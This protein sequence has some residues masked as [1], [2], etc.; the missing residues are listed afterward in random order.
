METGDA[1]QH[2]AY[3]LS[4]LQ[5]KEQL[6]GVLPQ[7]Q[8]WQQRVRTQFLD[9]NAA[10]AF[11]VEHGFAR[12][13][14]V[15]DYR[16]AVPLRT[17]ADFAP[18]VQ[19]V[20]AGEPAVLTAQD[21]KLFFH[22]SGSTGPSKTI[23]VTERFLSTTYLPFFRAAMG[24]PAEYF[25]ETVLRG[26]STL[27]LR[28]DRLTA[29]ATTAS[30]RPSLGPCQADLRRS[31]GVTVREPGWDAPWAELPVPVGDQDHMDKLYLRVRMAVEHDVRTVIGHNP[32]M[33]AVLPELLAQWWPLI[34]KEVHD[35]TYMGRPGGTPNPV[36]AREL[37]TMADYFGRP[38]PAM[39]W[40]RMQLLYCWTSGV[41]SLYLPRL[42]ELYGS[43]VTILPTPVVA[44]EGPVGV[45]IDRHPTAGPLS[46][47]TCLYEFVE[48]EQDLRADSP[49]LL[50]DELT[51]GRDYH[52]VFSHVGGLY[53]YVLGDL[54]HVVDHV[55]GVPRVEYAGRSNLM[56]GA[57]ERVREYHLVR[58]LQGAAT[59][60]GL[61]IV[62]VIS[63]L[64]PEPGSLH[65]DFAVA[66]PTEPE[67]GD[68]LS[69]QG[70]LDQELRAIAPGYS[71]ARSKGDIEATHVQ[72][73]PPSRFVEYWHH[74]V[75]AGRRP[76]EVKD[77]LIQPDPA[78][79]EGIAG[80]WNA[81]AA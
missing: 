18:W 17:Y 34:L 1:E 12:I 37:E 76:V 36:R 78:V 41:A 47:S 68:L 22:T 10:T 66:F 74:R 67:D 64:S 20:A 57:G 61:D 42:K 39:I 43:G 49:T 52:V 46:V 72:S 56:N 27:N 59:R 25:P 4:L 31:F 80:V 6:T 48:A 26:S 69:F 30:G 8:E 51:D 60:T 3:R 33:I 62:N 9:E 73:I 65:Y 5:A 58:A 75:D 7:A 38:T 54:V 29:P 81:C 44:S 14:S 40:P 11:G 24:V 23:P 16:A 28:H 63:R 53:R 21:P 79:F 70:A 19:R 15:D 71:S 2:Q 32:T 55:H 45:P 13:R 77:Q 35:G 50:F